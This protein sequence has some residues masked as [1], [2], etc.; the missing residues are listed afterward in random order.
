MSG[1]SQTI[2]DFTVS[3]LSQTVLDSVDLSFHMSGMII[4]HHRNLGHVR[5]IETLLTGVKKNPDCQ[6]TCNSGHQINNC[7][8]RSLML[9]IRT[10]HVNS[11]Y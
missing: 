7:N 1:K 3:D 2:G 5:K 8:V 4:D 9:I 6:N 10:L 11:V